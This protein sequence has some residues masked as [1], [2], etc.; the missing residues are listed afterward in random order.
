MAGFEARQVDAVGV[1]DAAPVG[2]LIIAVVALCAGVSFLD[3]F[4]IL[5]ISYVAPV[6]GAAWK[7][8]REAFGP[9][10]AAHYIGAAAG[11]VFFGWYADRYGRR[12]G[13]IVPT[14]IFGVFA[15]LTVYAY[16]FRSLFVLRM[17]IGIGLGGALSN[18]IAMVAEYSPQRARATL[19]SVMYA[20]FPL[21][22][23]I[24]GPIS[25]ALISHYGWHAVFVLGGVLPLLLTVALLLWLNESIR[26]MV[27]SKVA[28]ERIAGI[29]RRMAPG[30]EPT[31]GDV[32]V[33][34]QSRGVSNRPTREIFSRE[35]VRATVLL[36]IAAF[37]AQLVIV[38]V[39]T[40]M[41]LVLASIGMPV[42]S[43]ILASVAF[44][45]GGI[46]GAIG[47]ARIIDKDKS[48]R[49]LVVT[50]L[51]SA[52]S[53]AGIG[54]LASNWYGLL[55]ITF[56]TGLLTVGANIVL[57][58]YSATVYP[59][60]IRSTGVGWVIGWGRIGAIAGA[61][62]GTALVAAG[63]TIEIAYVIAAVPAIIGGAAI[64]MVRAKHQSVVV[65]A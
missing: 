43:A 39:V 1:V 37:M 64:A 40:W 16:D 56:L 57:S 54:Y 4:D 15:L 6:I 21:G 18:A 7:L 50:F 33:L 47:L 31:P 25:A 14:A 3:G 24:G 28:P 23:V 53:I 34:P 19:V 62:F 51:L 20:A 32:Y 11:S 38:Y 61:L 42:T 10:F 12:M 22:G 48:Y 46:F 49:G 52:V 30:F 63:L 45:V 60:A 29:L 35:F 5:A 9:I 65:Y 58:A 41:P 8:P 36:C 44:S 55:A 59:T 26:F 17:L 13:V 27:L 2:K